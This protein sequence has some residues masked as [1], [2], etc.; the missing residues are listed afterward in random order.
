[1]SIN[2]ALTAGNS[3]TWTFLSLWTGGV[4]VRAADVED[5]LVV[6]MFSVRS[7]GSRG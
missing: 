5:I 7:K 6:G 1:V 3:D 2:P 4:R